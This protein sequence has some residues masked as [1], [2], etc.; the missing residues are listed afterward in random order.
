MIMQGKKQIILALL[1]MSTFL[2]QSCATIISGTSQKIPVTS[3]PSGAKISVDGI[4]I[5]YTPMELK[6]KRKHDHHI[7][8]EKQGYNPLEIRVF[9]KKNSSLLPLSI[10]GNVFIFG[11]ISLGI[12]ALSTLMLL[13]IF[14]PEATLNELNEWSFAPYIAGGICVLSFIL[15]DF[16]SGALYTLSPEE[17]NVTLIKIEGKSQPNIILMDIEQFQNI[18]WIRIK[19]VDSDKEEIVSID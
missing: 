15:K 10:F 14:K 11:P 19:C 6:L 18:K 5:G 7:L 9:R 8:I 4:E 17:L 3:N 16:Q 13:V 2:F 12:G 1:V